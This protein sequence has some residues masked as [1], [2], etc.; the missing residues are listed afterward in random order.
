MSI[1]IQVYKVYISIY[2][3]VYIIAVRFPTIESAQLVELIQTVMD[4]KITLCEYTTQS[5][6]FYTFIRDT[7]LFYLQKQGQDCF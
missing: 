1:Y 4:E 7:F 2:I 6:M 5:F 3:H